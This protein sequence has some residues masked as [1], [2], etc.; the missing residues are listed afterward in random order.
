MLEKQ[1]K[2]RGSGHSVVSIVSAS[3]NRVQ[4]RGEKYHFN[5]IHFYCLTP[6][7]FF[8]FPTF[9]I[10]IFSYKDTNNNNITSTVPLVSIVQCSKSNIILGRIT[11]ILVKFQVRI[12]KKGDVWIIIM[13]TTRTIFLTIGIVY[14]IYVLFKAAQRN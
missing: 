5:K 14:Y 13:Y 1:S 11:L 7:P 2:D 12:L 6:P 3:T 8:K 4:G 10:T 9:L